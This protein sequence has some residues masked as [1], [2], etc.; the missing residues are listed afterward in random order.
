MCFFLTFLFCFL[1]WQAHSSKL[2]CHRLFQSDD[3]RC[4]SQFGGARTPNGH[5]TSN[6]ISSRTAKKT[7]SSYQKRKVLIFEALCNDNITRPF[8][9]DNDSTHDVEIKYDVTKT[10]HDEIFDSF[11]VSKKR[12]EEQ[13]KDPLKP[14]DYA[15]V[16]QKTGMIRI[17]CKRG[18]KSG[19]DCEECY[20]DKNTMYSLFFDTPL[21]ISLM[22]VSLH[23]CHLHDKSSDER[24]G[25]NE[26]R[27]IS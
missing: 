22:K 2:L 11:C 24:D 19:C 1:C 7:L 25:A 8:L 14:V 6:S 23:L 10:E 27:R 4:K 13:Q 21:L 20:K 16:Q 9:I 3:R 26:G 15:F 5:T 12:Q 17:P 18:A